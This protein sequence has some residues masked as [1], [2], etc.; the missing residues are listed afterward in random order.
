MTLAHCSFQLFL[1]K[2][3]R[4]INVSLLS[5]CAFAKCHT[6]YERWVYLHQ[7]HTKLWCSRGFCGF[8]VSIVTGSHLSSALD[9]IANR[10]VQLLLHRHKWVLQ[11]WISFSSLSFISQSHPHSCPLQYKGCSWMIL[12][13]LKVQPPALWGAWG[14]ERTIQEVSTTAAVW[15][16]TSNEVT[17]TY[18]SPALV[19]VAENQGA[20]DRARRNLQLNDCVRALLILS[21]P[22]ALHYAVHQ[23]VNLHTLIL[24]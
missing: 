16:S 8:R 11:I 14:A 19:S 12:C 6:E 17:R 1:S 23:Y 20:W 15:Y 4:M 2:V 24:A 13:L 5:V 9:S 18:P 21:P 22:A 3:I 10:W 7:K